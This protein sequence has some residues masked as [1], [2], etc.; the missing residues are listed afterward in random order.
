V[1]G[2]GCRVSAAG[3]RSRQHLLLL[4]LQLTELRGQLGTGAN[5]RSLERLVLL[6]RPPHMRVCRRLQ[7]CCVRPL[8]CR[9]L[10]FVLPLHTLQ[11]VLVAAVRGCCCGCRLLQLCCRTRRLL[12]TSRRAPARAC[13]QCITQQCVVAGHC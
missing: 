9:L 12:L 2:L 10:R 4:G 13:A 1:L 8:C 6:H 7:L 11:L 5:K 3:A